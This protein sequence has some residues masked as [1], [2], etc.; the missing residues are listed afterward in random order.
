MSW[1]IEKS[2]QKGSN[3]LVLL[4]IANTPTRPQ[5]RIFPAVSLLLRNRAHRGGVRYILR[6]LENSDELV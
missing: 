3:L 2:G 6:K 5:E 1:V 4:M